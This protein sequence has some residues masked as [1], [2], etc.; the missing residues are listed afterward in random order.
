MSS[1][2]PY[3]RAPASAETTTI[4]SIPRPA[5]L[6][7]T[8]GAAPLWSLSEAPDPVAPGPLPDVRLAPATPLPVGVPVAVAEL[9]EL[10]KIKRGSTPPSM[11]HVCSSRT[12]CSKLRQKYPHEPFHCST[13]AFLQHLDSTS[14]VLE[15]TP[16][17]PPTAHAASLVGNSEKTAEPQVEPALGA[18]VV[19]VETTDDMVEGCWGWWFCSGG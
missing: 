15:G 13:G 16:L 12:D 9:F 5:L 11:K 8:A 7:P 17:V 2:P 14:V 19:A 4:P 3:N 6:T 18:L 10:Q 1:P